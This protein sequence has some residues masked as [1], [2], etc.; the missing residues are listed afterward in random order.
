MKTITIILAL[1]L[2]GCAV[3]S[4]LIVSEGK[5][6]AVETLVSSEWFICKGAPIGIIK[7]HYR[8]REEIYKAFC[9]SDAKVILE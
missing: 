1:F 8:G 9:K 5:R 3:T 7:N 6:I 2:S 4:Q